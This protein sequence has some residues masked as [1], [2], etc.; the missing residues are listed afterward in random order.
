MNYYTF[1]K[2]Y[3]IFYAFIVI[4]SNDFIDSTRKIRSIQSGWIKKNLSVNS[5][6][7]KKYTTKL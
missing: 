4:K 6:A 3:L 7:G 2:Y 1:K 5:G